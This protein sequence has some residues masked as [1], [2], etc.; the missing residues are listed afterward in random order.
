[1][2]IQR[3]RTTIGFAMVEAGQ[4]FKDENDELFMKTYVIID[5]INQTFNAVR[6]LTG[7]PFYFRDDE[8]V[9]LARYT[10]KVD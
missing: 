8:Q 5:A 7:A 1:M 3:N 2:E 9:S 6:L 10:F 4:I